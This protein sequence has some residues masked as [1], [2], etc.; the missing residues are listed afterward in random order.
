MYIF[1]NCNSNYTPTFFICQYTYF[2]VGNKGKIPYLSMVEEAQSS[3]GAIA[4]VSSKGKGER[5][6]PLFFRPLMR[7]KTDSV[8]TKN[9]INQTHLMSVRYSMTDDIRLQTKNRKTTTKKVC[10]RSVAFA[11]ARFA[12][13]CN[14]LT[15]ANPFSFV[16]RSLIDNA[17]RCNH[18]RIVSPLLHSN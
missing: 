12:M 15:T 14:A 10:F 8:T 11:C 4:I 3:V 16:L 9:S 1:G 17:N 5:C 6:S 7:T 2:F 18:W 13:R